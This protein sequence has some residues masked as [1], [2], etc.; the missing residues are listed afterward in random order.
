MN[1]KSKEKK[2][3]NWDNL[4]RCPRCENRARHRKD[5]PVCKGHGF[6]AVDP[7]RFG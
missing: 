6:V 7:P 4:K 2:K 3:I 5:C 1:E